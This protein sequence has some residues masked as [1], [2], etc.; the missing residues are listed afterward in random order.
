M[1]LNGC[2]KIIKVKLY[3]WKG[4]KWVRNRYKVKRNDKRRWHVLASYKRQ[5]CKKRSSEGAVG[6]E[7]V[8]G[9]LLSGERR[10]VRW[11]HCRHKLG[12][13]AGPHSLLLIFADAVHTLGS[14]QSYNNLT[15]DKGWE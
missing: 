12:P 14:S 3:G 4:S 1:T 9:G 7:K 6:T 15:W 11:T 2:Q 10:Q 5:K 13:S 8:E